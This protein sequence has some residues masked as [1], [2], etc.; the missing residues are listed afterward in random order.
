MD[1]SHHQW[2]LDES[3]VDILPRL[4]LPLAGPTPD[5]FDPEEIDALPMDLQYLDEDKAVETD[6]DLKKMI[7]EA[8]YQLCAT[9]SCREYIRSKN[10]YLI[11]REL[12]KSEPDQAMKDTIEDVV[13][14]LIKKEDEIQADDLRGVD[15]PKDVQDQIDDESSQMEKL[16]V[17]D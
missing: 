5:T 11:L 12:H 8:L 1:P 6:P 9:R 10:A 14:L 7:L 15:V 13:Q 16:N 3:Q 17:E 2:L 4:L